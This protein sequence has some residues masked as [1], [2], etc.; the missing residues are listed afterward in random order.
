M[1]YQYINKKNSC[2]NTEYILENVLKDLL[3][4]PYIKI[5]EDYYLNNI[6]FINLISI[7]EE[8]RAFYDEIHRESAPHYSDTVL[9]VIHDVFKAADNLNDREKEVFFYHCIKGYSLY[10]LKNGCNDQYILISNVYNIYKQMIQ[11]IVYTSGLFVVYDKIEYKED[12]QY[13]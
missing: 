9:Y 11:D 4:L 2:K 12:K 1:N 5:N 8:K 3:A 10:E 13:A 6:Q 7:D